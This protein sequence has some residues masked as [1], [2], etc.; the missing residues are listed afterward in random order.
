MSIKDV[1]NG[2]KSS[3]GT[4]PFRS[5]GDEVADLHHRILQILRD[6]SVPSEYKQQFRSNNFIELFLKEFALENVGGSS[7]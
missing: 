5:E 1:A 6:P 3:P 2:E 7:K 4:V